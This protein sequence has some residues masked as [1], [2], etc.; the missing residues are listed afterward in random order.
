MS[1]PAREASARVLLSWP[2]EIRVLRRFGLRDGMRV[3]DLGSGSC[4]AAAELLRGFPGMALVGLEPDPAASVRARDATAP[5]AD[6]FLA[7]RASADR[8]PFRAGSFDFVL[9]RLVFQYVPDPVEAARQALSVLRPGGR[10][11]VTDVDGDLSY[12]L[13]P[14][15]PGLDRVMARYDAWHRGRGGDRSVGGR[16]RAILT[17]AGAVD[18][19][20]ETI[21]FESRAET[22]ELYLDVLVG[23]GRMRALR[24]AGYVTQAEIDD[25]LA[26]RAQWLLSPGRAVTR[27]LRMACGAV[28]ASG[29]R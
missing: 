19:Q 25:F 8:V 2:E 6:R 10:L 4:V 1:E 9:A 23:P 12:A 5:V 20:T 27:Y 7:V 17:E 11:T 14:P 21:R 13:D 22:A 15:L 3:L 24:E 26:A 28:P 16:L 18:V 29:L